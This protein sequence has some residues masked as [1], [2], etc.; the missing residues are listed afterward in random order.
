MQAREGLDADTRTAASPPC[1]TATV[2]PAAPPAPAAPT[3]GAGADRLADGRPAFDALFATYRAAVH[4]YVY[5][6]MGDREDAYDL[7]QE[8]FL[9]VYLDLPRARPAHVQG[10]VYRVATNVCLDALRHRALVRWT[11]LEGRPG[12]AWGDGGGGGVGREARLALATPLVRLWRD[13]RSRGGGGADRPPALGVARAP[14]P[15]TDPERCALRAEQAREVHAVLEQLPPRYRAALVLRE[16]RGL[17]Y[18][19]IGTA[20]GVSLS[21]VKTVLFRARVRFREEWTRTCDRPPSAAREAPAPGA[22]AHRNATAGR[23]RK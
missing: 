9:R 19:E 20:L 11:S 6:L 14:D 12:V 18:A 22:E 17:S 21:A 7:T 15:D 5:R 3:S 1:I 8:A 4:N 23:A 10:W 13:G 16:W 2:A